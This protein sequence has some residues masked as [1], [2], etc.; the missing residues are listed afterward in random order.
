[1]VFQFSLAGTIFVCFIV[2]VRKQKLFAE[3]LGEALPAAVQLCTATTERKDYN[4]ELRL[5]DE[6][7]R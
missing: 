6:V 2:N 3:I 5:Q 7:S 1:M 4:T